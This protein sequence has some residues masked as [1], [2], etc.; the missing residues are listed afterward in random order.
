MTERILTRHPQGKSGKNIPREKYHPV[1]EAIVAAL[2]QGELTHSELMAKVEASLRGRFEGNTH[3]YGETVKLDL[4]AR[5]IIE[6]VG[7]KP[8]RYRR[9][10]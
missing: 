4:E 8:E 10:R 1:K 2:G 5:R 7:S 6:R 3:W 9:I